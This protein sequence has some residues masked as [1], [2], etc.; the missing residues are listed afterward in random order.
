MIKPV[1]FFAIL[2]VCISC[3]QTNKELKIANNGVSNYRI[4]Y[5]SNASDSI[6]QAVKT[7]QTQLKYITGADIQAFADIVGEQ[8][9]EILIGKS[10]RAASKDVPYSLLNHDGYYSGIHGKKWVIGGLNATAI[11]Q[12]LFD[13]ITRSGSA[14]LN[15]TITQYGQNKNFTI[16]GETIFNPS[17]SY[18]QSLNPYAANSEYRAFN[19]I[20]IDNEKDWGTWEYSMERIFPNESYNKSNPEIF[21]SIQG[22]KVSNQINFTEPNLIPLLEKNLDVWVMGKGRAKYWSISPYDNHIVSDD[23]RTQQAIKETGSA[24]GPLIKVANEIA[25]KN[26]ERQYALFLDGPYRQI[27]TLKPL[28]NVM[29]VLDT[30]DIDNTSSLGEGSINEPFRKD[31]EAWQK[32]TDNIAVMMH[33]T[34]GKYFMA[35][36]PNLT[37]LQKSLQYL[38]SKGIHK[39]IFSGVSSVGSSLCDLKFYVASNLAYNAQQSLDSLLDMYCGN[40][41]GAG[42]SNI[43]GFIKGLENA[44]QG[45]KTPLFY[46]SSPSE[47]FRSWFSP[48]NINQLYSYYNSLI[49]LAQNN[50]QLKELV[51]IDRLALIYTQLEIAKA[52][53]SKTY[54]YFMNI[55]ALSQLVR[56]E[57]SKMKS[58]EEL[59][60]K[61]AKWGAI[62]GMKALIDQFVSD[63]NR[64]GVRAVDATGLTPDQYK[65]NLLQ[66][67]NQAIQVHGGFKKGTI[68]FNASPD[69]KFCDGDGSILNDGVLGTTNSISTNWIGLSGDENEITYSFDKD[70]TLS[71]VDI[72]FLQSTADR[73]WLPSSITCSISADGNT[74]TA[75]KTITV[76]PSQNA[77]QIFNAT[78]GL[79]KKNIKSIKIKTTGK[80]LCPG[81]HP[82]SGSPAVIL[83]DEIIVN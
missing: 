72:R 43:K 20:N 75:V 32:L 67:V 30:R 24:A 50:S 74:Y 22:K 16:K 71:T 35:P 81:D 28:S 48:N 1:A 52:M 51:D 26:K 56:A 80:K 4:I 31:L 37:G 57:Q 3:N 29:L 78:F 68:S 73:A 27:S 5:A 7:F 66:Y 2:L 38:Q 45:G 18:R 65:E 42:A 40:K 46:N 25:Q 83:T 19:H 49:Q 9:E 41:Y 76:P 60:N 70:T 8:S 33:I 12:G 82:L 39:V 14:K 11:T 53:G 58:V 63:C 61:Q 54:G 64:L 15:T 10:N 6:N 77:L 59:S 44:A 69:P 21:A 23:A 62:T 55:G 34:N 36:Y 47:S 17:F 13:I 79:G